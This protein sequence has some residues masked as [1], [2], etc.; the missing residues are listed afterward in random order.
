MDIYIYIYIYHMN[1]ISQV[2]IVY[3]TYLSGEVSRRSSKKNP[4][5]KVKFTLSAYSREN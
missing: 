2:K 4:F 3:G 5:K 1:D